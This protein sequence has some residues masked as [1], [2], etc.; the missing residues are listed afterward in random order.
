M[1]NVDVELPGLG[2]DAGTEATVSVFFKEPG[3]E[4]KEGE[5]LVEMATDKAT[6]TVP[7]P[8]GGKV[9][10][11]LVSEDDVVRVGEGLARIEVAD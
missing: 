5:D 2:D 8:V 4:V 1:P 9:V 3:E 7:S 11:L 6:F 10:E